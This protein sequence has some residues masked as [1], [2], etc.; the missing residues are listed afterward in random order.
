[1]II[2]SSTIPY[3]SVSG[4][5][6]SP[7]AL[8]SGCRKRRS[9]KGV[10]SLFFSFSG[11]F[12]SLFGHFFSNASV[13]FSAKL[14]CQ[15]P[16]AGLLLRPIAIYPI[17]SSNRTAFFLVW[18]PFSNAS[19]TFFAKLLCQTPFAGLLLRQGA[20]Y[21]IASSN[22]TAFFLVWAPLFECSTPPHKRPHGTSFAVYQGTKGGGR[23]RRSSCP[24]EA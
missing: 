16:F 5:F 7:I 21:P 19:V 12:R 15:T 9:A 13:T 23:Y 1:M 4:G 22:R 20:I 24:Q 6:G 8:Y 10:R 18:H 2:P 14:L 11:L 3:L 17:A